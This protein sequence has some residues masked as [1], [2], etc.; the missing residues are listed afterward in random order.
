M[1]FAGHRRSI[2]AGRPLGECPQGDHV[3]TGFS[4]HIHLS[5]GFQHISTRHAGS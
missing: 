4:N 2:E 1:F 5:N 3:F